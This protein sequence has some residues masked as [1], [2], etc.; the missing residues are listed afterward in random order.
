MYK[1]YINGL[2]KELSNHSLA[3]SINQLKLNPPTFVDDITVSVTSVIFA[4]PHE[5]MLKL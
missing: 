4:S 2:L 5:N 3:I 1:V